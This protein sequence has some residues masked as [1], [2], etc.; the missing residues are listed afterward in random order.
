MKQ[1]LLQDHTLDIL[2]RL[3]VRYIVLWLTCFLNKNYS[4]SRPVSF[5]NHCCTKLAVH[6]CFD[7]PCRVARCPV[8]DRTVRFF[9]DLSGQKLDAK[10]DN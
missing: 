6:I 2:L 4:L 3:L 9:G 1:V 7:I 10:P 5:M 8:F